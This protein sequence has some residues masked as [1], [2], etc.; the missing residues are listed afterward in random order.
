L[1]L[2]SANS[3][4]IGE[5]VTQLEHALQAAA[6]ADRAG[7]A[8]SEV[9]A[10]LLHDVGHLCAGPDA[11]DMAG[12]GIVDHEAIGA[13]WLAD[14]GFGDDVTDL[15]AAHVQAKRYLVV[16]RPEYAARLSEASAETLR[17]QGAAMSAKEVAAFDAH[18]RRDARLR[19]RSWDE[20]A[21]VAGLEVPGVERY[22]LR[23][24]RYLADR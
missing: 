10:A 9:I 4:Y 22:R 19:V 20:Q 8:D 24:V 15:V 16:T 12:L 2:A 21:K 17:H 5:D 11:R 7:V 14:L 18:P 23:I 3:G 6:S 13:L 1:L